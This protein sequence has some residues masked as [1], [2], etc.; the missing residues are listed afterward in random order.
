MRY[1]N[2]TLL[3]SIVTSAVALV[4]TPAMA[5]AGSGAGQGADRSPG[6]GT[7][8][9]EVQ[10]ALQRDLGLSADQAKRHGALQEQAITLDRK[11][12]ASLGDAFAGSFYEATTGKLVVMVSDPTKLDEARAAG[13]DA[14]QA[15]HSR[16]KLETIK[17]E[18]DR[19]SGKA[20]GSSPADRKPTGA[21]QA[22]V[23]AMTTWYI[24]DTSNSLVVTAA[25]GKAADARRALA[26]YGDAVTIEESDLD[27][28]PTAFM[29]GGD[30]I[31]SSSCS[32][33]FNLRNAATGKGYLL[34]AGH[35]VS[36]G[37]TLRGQGG[38]NF[39]LVL[40]SWFPSFDDAIARNDNTSSWVQGKW[41]DTNPSNGGVIITNSY[42]DAPT[43]TSM[44]KSGI[45]TKWTCGK[46]TAKNETVTYTGG[47]TVYGLTR[48]NACVEP[49]DSGGANVSIIN[50]TYAA[51]G[52]T[53]G[54]SM[55]E[56][57]GKKRCR[58]ALWPGW[59]ENISWY[60]PI[61]DSLAFYGP[62]YGVAPW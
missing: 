31:N 52:V 59:F 2:A 14:R 22:S 17:E 36:A 47:Q 45:T 42:T 29:D 61:A 62:K 5:A 20:P 23:A 8:P 34:T 21:R 40:D 56:I 6:G 7:L 44:C 43:G 48:H 25:K 1:K 30:L 54:A 49:G 35:C 58:S 10:V 33:G 9:P 51:E 16:A 41:V 28:T 4:A 46:I 55:F 11:L 15:R 38:V 37:S 18:L 26:K 50:G 24:D 19:A 60:F 13:A 53:S 3:A 27:P 12:R 32:A 57:D 39:G